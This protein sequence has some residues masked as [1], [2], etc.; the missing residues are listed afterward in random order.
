MAC[1]TRRVLAMGV[2]AISC[3]KFSDFQSGIS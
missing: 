1:S 3:F 2:K